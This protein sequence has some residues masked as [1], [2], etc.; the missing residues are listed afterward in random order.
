MRVILAWAT[1][2]SAPLLSRWVRRSLLVLAGALLVCAPSGAALAT[3]ACAP[4]QLRARLAATDLSGRADAQSVPTQLEL[5]VMLIDLLSIDEVQQRFSADLR[6]EMSWRDVRLTQDALGC[7]PA[8]ARLPLAAIW[9]PR[10]VLMNSIDVDQTLEPIIQ[11]GPEGRLRLVQRYTGV[12][13]SRMALEDFPLE[14]QRLR[15]VI[16]TALLGPDQVQIRIDPDRS[17]VFGTTTVA[18]WFVESPSSE[19]DTAR[20]ADVTINR[21]R[22]AFPARRRPG[23]FAYKVVLPLALIVAMSWSVFWLD[24]EK[25]DAQLGVASASVLTLIAFQLSLGDLLPRIPYL[26]RL[27]RFVLGSTILVFAA[28][29]EVI[30]TSSLA[31][32]ERLPAARRLDRFSRYAF[33]LVYGAFALWCFA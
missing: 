31:T 5:G 22:Y 28:L 3:P 26:T 33:P 15:V 7:D 25:L 17:G 29:A 20:I 2:S 18:G 4:D 12:F 6:L 14:T 27:D 30:L 19:V 21:I 11:I 10:L 23:Y 13:S 1:V 8:D 32:R 24:P 9:H 16:G